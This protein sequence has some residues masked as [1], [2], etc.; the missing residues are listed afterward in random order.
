MKGLCW[1][2]EDFHK[3]DDTEKAKLS[4]LMKVFMDCAVDYST[5]RI[6]ALGAVG[7]A[8]QVV[9]FDAE[10]RNRV[11]EVEV[12]LMTEAEISAVIDKG[13]AALNLSFPENVKTVI[14]KYSSG[15]GAVCHQLCLNLCNAANI[16][17]TQRNKTPITLENLEKAI[18]IYVSECSD[19]IRNNFEKA[20]KLSRKTSVAH[21]DILLDALSHF[22]DYG[23]DRYRLLKQIQKTTP[24]YTDAV[25]KKQLPPLMKDLKGGL[26]KY[27][28]NSGLYAFSNPI[29]RAFAL[30]LFHKNGKQKHDVSTDTMTL[31]DL[32]RLLEKELRA[33]RDR[34]TTRVIKP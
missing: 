5:V 21:A 28:E 31:P 24:S 13:A 22:D 33:V 4:Q 7:T 1:V 3:V 19:T 26:I 23:T 34:Q 8:R 32:L 15:L 12:D 9:E 29:N 17:R 11:A 16:Q 27:S 2:I 18:A 10:M 20:R 14:A 25:L 30:S 6:I